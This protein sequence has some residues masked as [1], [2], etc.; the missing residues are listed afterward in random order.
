MP[1]EPSDDKRLR[2]SCHRETS[3]ANREAR[4]TCRFFAPNIQRG[5]SDFFPSRL[6]PQG[7]SHPPQFALGEIGE[8]LRVCHQHTRGPTGQRKCNRCIQNGQLKLGALERTRTSDPQLRKLMLYPLSYERVK[9]IVYRMLS[10]LRVFCDRSTDKFF[11]RQRTR[12]VVTLT[13]LDA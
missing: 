7:K 4:V 10:G 1:A 9:Q 12:K 6:L 3:K 13:V 11:E 2:R 8:G 5:L